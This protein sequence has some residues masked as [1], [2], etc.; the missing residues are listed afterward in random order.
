MNFVALL[1]D[2]DPD[3]GWVWSNPGSS[4]GQTFLLLGIILALVV[5]IF[6][7]AAVWRKPRRRHHHSSVLDGS[8][9]ALPSPRKRR[10]KLSR[11]LSGKRH[12]RRRRSGV[13]RPI[14]PTLAQ[15]GGLPAPRREQPPPH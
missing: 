8:S 10:S 15:V 11:L 6:I 13:E 7:W 9:L 3:S 1:A 2:A 12:R 5:V 4:V 14:N